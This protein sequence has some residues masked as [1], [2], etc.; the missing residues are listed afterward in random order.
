VIPKPRS[1]FAG[2]LYEHVRYENGAWPLYRWDRNARYLTK[3]LVHRRTPW[4]EAD[5]DHAERARSYLEAGTYRRTIEGRTTRLVLGGDL[6]WVRRR[7]D[8][9]LSPLLRARIAAADVAFANLESPVVPERAVP[10]YT[11]ETLRYNAPREVLDAWKS[12]NAR[13]LSLCN[14]HAL[15]QGL[16]GLRRTREVVRN[17]GIHAL[18]GADSGDEGAAFRG[19]D[20]TFAALGVTYGINPGSRGGGALVPPAGVP[21]VRF[22][23]PSSPPDFARLARHLE[24]L[25]PADVRV[26]VAH[27]GFEYEHFPG[28]LQRAH[29]RELLSMGFDVIV[30]SSPHVLQP[31]EIV[32]IDGADASCPLSVTRPTGLSQGPRFGLVAWSL[33]NLCTI[34]PTLPCRVGAL[35][36][37]DLGLGASHDLRISDVRAVPT[38]SA[39]GLAGDWLSGATLSLDEVEDLAARGEPCRAAEWRCREHAESILGSLARRRHDAR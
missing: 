3:S 11:Y 35:V 16:E 22:G 36:E 6:M 29:A 28:E 20:L 27:W 18:G 1:P 8:A 24:A 5:R 15:D 39:R 25:G 13:V 32:S 30:G 31:V 21:V 34:M 9:A 10:T 26:L 17:E 37:I 7:F 33:G 4:T 23:D 38:V 19:G 14:N 12:P 2:R